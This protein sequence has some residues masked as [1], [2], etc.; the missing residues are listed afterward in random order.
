MK[1]RL[2]VL[3]ILAGLALCGCDLFKKKEADREWDIVP[4]FASGTEAEKYFPTGKHIVDV[5]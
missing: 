4:E 2:L 5:C 1:K 3:P